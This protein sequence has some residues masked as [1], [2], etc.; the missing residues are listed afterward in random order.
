[1]T[2]FVSSAPV[3][4]T[5]VLSIDDL[6]RRLRPVVEEL[7]YILI[8]SASELEIPGDDPL[9]AAWFT[10]WERTPSGTLSARQVITGLADELADFTAALSALRSRHG[11]EA[12]LRL[13]D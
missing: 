13:V 6:P 7:M 4:C 10:R 1:M 5:A 3:A 9:T 8:P 12:E 11:F 2:T